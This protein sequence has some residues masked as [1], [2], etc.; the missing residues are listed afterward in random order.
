M[1]NGLSK[2]RI[3]CLVVCTI[4]C[5]AFVSDLKSQVINEFMS[6]NYTFLYD[7][8]GEDND[9]I[10]IYNNTN[11]SLSLKNYFLTDDKSNYYKWN[12]PDV[13]LEADSFLVI[14]ASDKDTVF[15]NSEIHTNFSIKSH[16]EELFLINSSHIIQK[17]E[18]VKLMQNQ[19]YGLFPDGSVDAVE[20][21]VATPG[22]K[23]ELIL[24]EKVKFNKAGGVYDDN[25]ELEL[26]NVFSENEIRYTIDGGTPDKNSLLYSNALFLDENVCSKTDIYKI[27]VS[28]LDLQYIPEK[29]FPKAIVIRAA[30]FDSTGNIQSKVITNSYFIK[31]MEID[32][33]DLPIISITA[34][35]AFLFDDS[36]G[37]FVPGIYYDENYHYGAERT[38]NYY[39]KGDEWERRANVEYFDYRNS[40]FFSQEIGLRIHG[41]KARRFP[42]KAMR[43]YARAEYGES[44][45]YT[46]LFSHEIQNSYKRLVLK[47][48][49]SSWTSAGFTDL[50][51]LKI[52]SG[53]RCKSPDSKP[54]VLYL[55]G[56][57]WG[58]YFISERIDEKYLAENYDV[59]E[60]S[61][62][63]V[64]GW[65]GTTDDGY[66]EDFV[67][68]YNYILEND[69]TIDQN[70]FYVS[71]RIDI[72]DFID[73]LIFEMYSNNCDWPDNNMAC[74]KS[75]EFDQNW[76]WIFFDGDACFYP[77]NY[78]TFNHATNTTNIGWPTNAFST[79][80]FRKLMKNQSFFSS[81]V[82]RLE[83][84]SETVF[85]YSQTEKL[86][87]NI[88]AEISEEIEP[89][90]ERFNIPLSEEDWNS[91]CDVIDMFLMGRVCLMR[92]QFNST[93]DY[94]I[95]LVSCG[96]EIIEVDNFDI[97]PNP[98]TDFISLFFKN[99]DVS[100]LKINISDMSGRL[101]KE[102]EIELNSVNP[103]IEL[104]VSYLTNGAY[105]IKLI[106][107]YGI[108]SKK[109]IIAK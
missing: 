48:F 64:E 79:L 25:F 67:N 7:Y 104:D 15:P 38:G 85:S 59:N 84:L 43:I 28:P 89:Q 106:T 62:E 63:L 9:W 31:D 6:S 61:V 50:L 73:Y 109:L 91:S 47:P 10:E 99:E 39:Q 95:Y 17:I 2:I 70:Y 22:R 60:N 45:F 55:N 98:A 78:N 51:A 19:S 101:I 66:S 107:A 8:E 103:K 37:I 30:A 54:A 29:I 35:Y 21:D 18:P 40:D 75:D 27:Q 24:I 83:R 32:H 57:Y 14:F 105:I 97:Y 41:D 96:D 90:S 16:G 87:N 71:Q 93:F 74:W 92:D 5:I 81:F 77:Y 13:I 100:C 53:L 52:S 108:E 88:K 102:F 49:S 11:H 76:R 94:Y 82:R 4:N 1:N 20:F 33:D 23:N 3:I 80:F 58:V 72:K 56:E 36:T 34:D 68:L 44:E 42:Q 12:F 86:L 65:G 26:S 69:L 46:K